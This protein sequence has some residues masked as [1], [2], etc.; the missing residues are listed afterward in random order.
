MLHLM[1]G[2]FGP[3]PT[4][5]QARVA[6]AD[7]PTLEAWTGRLLEAKSVDEIFR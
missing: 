5:I 3:L 1:E 2:R 4:A 7:L 6:K